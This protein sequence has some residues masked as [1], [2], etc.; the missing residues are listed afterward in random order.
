VEGPKELPTFSRAQ[1]LIAGL[2]IIGVAAAAVLLIRPRVG[3]ITFSPSP[4][5]APAVPNIVLIL[6]D[7]QRWDSMWAMPKTRHLLADHGVQFTNGFVV[8]SLCC[9]SRASILTGQYSHGTRVYTNRPPLGGFDAFDPTTTIATVLQARGYRTALIGKYLNGYTHKKVPPGWDTWDAFNNPSRGVSYFDYSM[10]QNGKEV[11]Y[12]AAPADYS[13]DVLAGLATSFIAQSHQPFFLYF[14]PSAPHMPAVTAPR[15]AHVF[16][17]LE[18]FRPPAFDEADTSDKPPWLRAVPPFDAARI[19]KED[20]ILALQ[21]RS[22]PP[23]DDAV[24]SIVDA[25]K[26]T[27]KLHDT[28]ILFMS[29]NGYMNGEH[30]LGGKQ[31]P[32]EES[33]RVPMILRYDPLTSRARKDPRMAL[34]IDL[35]PTFADIAGAQMPDADGSSLLDL[36]RDPK[37]PGRRWFLIEHVEQAGFAGVSTDDEGPP[38]PSYCAVRSQRWKYVYYADRSQEL[39]DL[40]HDPFEMNN[41]IGV[42]S[43]AHALTVASA[44]LH[45]LCVPPPPG[46]KLP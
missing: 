5:A 18:P 22:L 7:D 10:S 44:E 30:R 34:N 29:D 6:T 11:N 43:A 19:A 39:Y 25:L 3:G 42:A 24:Q 14:A 16:P 32:Y 28:L 36:I 21:D 12:G 40:V 13:T 35:A 26:A 27:G 9:P 46:L 15:Y 4:R 1:V 33:I 45:R 31:V 17:N 38:V 8:N 23:V 41:L 20:A 2:L 37:M